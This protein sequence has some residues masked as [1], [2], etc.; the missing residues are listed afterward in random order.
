[1]GF[2]GRIVRPPALDTCIFRTLRLAKWLPTRTHRSTPINSRPLPPTT[3]LRFRLCRFFVF[4]SF[5]RAIALKGGGDPFYGIPTSPPKPNSRG[6]G[7]PDQGAYL[8]VA[9]R[10]NQ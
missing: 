2:G 3:E 4:F 10:L 7:V 9:D 5:C 1:M 8:F 6:W